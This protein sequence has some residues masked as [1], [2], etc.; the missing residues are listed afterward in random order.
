M[1]KNENGSS[2]NGNGTLNGGPLPEI[3]IVPESGTRSYLVKLGSIPADAGTIEP[4][5]ICDG[6]T[7]EPDS[8]V[9]GPIVMG[10]GSHVV[11]VRLVVDSSCKGESI[12]VVTVKDTATEVDVLNV[13]LALAH[14]G[15]EEAEKANSSE[16]VRKQPELMAAAKA[17]WALMQKSAVTQSS[18]QPIVD[19]VVDSRLAAAAE[20][21][22]MIVASKAEA[23]A[24]QSAAEHVGD[25]QTPIATL[26]AATPPTDEPPTPGSSPQVTVTTTGGNTTVKVDVATGTGSRVKVGEITIDPVTQA[27]TVTTA[28]GGTSDQ[29]QAGTAPN[30]WIMT[31]RSI[32]LDGRSHSINLE[33][34]RLPRHLMVEFDTQLIQLI[35][36]DGEPLRMGGSYT[37][38]VKVARLTA[39]DAPT[40]VE[41]LATCVWP[42]GRHEIAT[43]ITLKP[44]ED[45]RGKPMTA[46]L[47]VIS[48]VAAFCLIG[49]MA[50][51]SG[52]LP[53]FPMWKCLWGLVAAAADAYYINELRHGA[54]LRTPAALIAAAATF[55]AVTSAILGGN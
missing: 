46:V 25:Q 12:A 34:K 17:N 4:W 48:L 32:P 27:A 42:E 53:G 20:V 51:G 23:L 10:N 7:I 45:W 35:Q 30:G 54:A 5:V 8:L 31:P 38:P 16:A 29:P 3:L 24:A 49:T 15:D 13:V 37:I 36:P 21:N 39:T 9:R 18:D 22:A 40:N 55:F 52:K 14:E 50:G 2:G 26:A 43:A 44:M 33:G 41:A 19:A 28:T 11:Y 47:F 6:V 1:S